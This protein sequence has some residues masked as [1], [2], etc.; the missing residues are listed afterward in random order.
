MKIKVREITEG[1]K[2]EILPQGDW[3]DLRAAEDIVLTAPQAGSRRRKTVNNEIVSYRDV[4]LK[5]TPIRLGIAMHLPSGFEAVMLPRSSTPS[6][7]GIMC[8]NS[9]GVIDNTYK[10]N[11]DEWRFP[12]IALR[13]AVIHKGDRI[14]QF[15]IQLSQ[16]ATVWQKLR[17]LFSSK[18]KFVWVDSLKYGNRG[19]FG[20]TGIK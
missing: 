5:V 17:W 2:F 1:C 4:T 12:A 18:I 13:N 14:C 8:A 15:R 6:K 10:G 11:E 3:I 16:K 20:T 19:G 7:L 9:Q